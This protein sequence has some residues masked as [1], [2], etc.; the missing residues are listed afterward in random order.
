MR[1]PPLRTK[2]SQ[3]ALLSVPIVWWRKFIY[4][5]SLGKLRVFSKSP[6]GTLGTSFIMVLEMLPTIHLEWKQGINHDI[7][8]KDGWV[9]R[10][11]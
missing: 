4:F 10:G 2:R 1:R 5:S 8:L 6:I 11:N 7:L 3:I 9:K